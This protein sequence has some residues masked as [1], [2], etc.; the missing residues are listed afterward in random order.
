MTSLSE[1]KINKSLEEIYLQDN[2]KI[3]KWLDEIKKPENQ[4]DGKIPGLFMKSLTKIK[5]DGEVYNLILQWIKD[6]R[7][8]FADYDFTGV[9]DST[10]VSLDNSNVIRKYQLR[11]W[12]PM[13]ILKNY[14]ISKNPNAVDY[15]KDYRDLIKW[16][17]LSAN[18]NAIEL[19]R[20]KAEEENN[21]ERF[22]LS[23]MADY[24]KLDWKNLSANP[25]TVELLKQY[26]RN[27]K[28][29]RLSENTNLEAIELLKEK[30]EKESKMKESE[31]VRLKDEDKIDWNQLCLHP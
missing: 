4:K 7:D 11:S 17:D 26:R 15:L 5:T 30:I 22:D 16:N 6:N 27:I 20:E 29:D 13:N 1:E 31:L 18:P 3:I 24:K 9:P 28:W 23:R 10:F 12:I 25:G 14:N 8:K 21:V 19:L 2:N